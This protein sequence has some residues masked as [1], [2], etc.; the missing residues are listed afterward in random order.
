MQVQ[1]IAM[2]S[3]YFRLKMQYNDGLGIETIFVT[4]DIESLS[5]LE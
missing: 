1:M 2:L 3:D 4:E 5:R